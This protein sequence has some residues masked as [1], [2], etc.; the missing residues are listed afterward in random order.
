MLCQPGRTFQ[1]GNPK[2][3]KGNP[4]GIWGSFRAAACNRVTT[5]DNSTGCCHVEPKDSPSVQSLQEKFT[6]HQ[7]PKCEIHLPIHRHRVRH[8]KPETKS[9]GM[10]ESVVSSS[11]SKLQLLST[12]GMSGWL[13]HSHSAQ[14]H[15]NCFIF[16]SMP[17]LCLCRQLSLTWADAR[18]PRGSPW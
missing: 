15:V 17:A 6:T 7:V 14:M 2:S 16:R 4:R 11:A 3:R 18:I 1:V 13:I 8:P 5:E 12:A 9:S 10:G